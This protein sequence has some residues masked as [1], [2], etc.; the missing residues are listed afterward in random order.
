MK[1]FA[2]ALLLQIEAQT[3]RLTK[4]FERQLMTPHSQMDETMVEYE[5]WLRGAGGEVSEKIK[6]GFIDAKKRLAQLQQLEDELEEAE[7]KGGE[8]EKSAGKWMA[9]YRMGKVKKCQILKL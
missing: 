1:I 4:L 3:G 8:G 5:E 7:K 9:L 2:S 6:K